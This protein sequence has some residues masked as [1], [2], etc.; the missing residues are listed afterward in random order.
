[1]KINNTINRSLLMS[2]G[3]GKTKPPKEG[4]TVPNKGTPVKKKK[5]KK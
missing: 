1:M 5:D 3:G 2:G 4:E